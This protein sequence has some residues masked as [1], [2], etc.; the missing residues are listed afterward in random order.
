MRRNTN[1]MKF[2]GV[3]A[4][5]GVCA[6]SAWGQSQNSRKLDSPNG[7]TT[8]ERPSQQIQPLNIKPGLWETTITHNV[9]GAPPIPAEMLNRLTPEQRARMEERM[10]ANSAAHT[11]SSTS[12]GCTTKEDLQK[13]KLHLGKECT[14]TILASSSTMAKGKVSCESEGVKTTGSLEIE[15]LDQE[16][17]KGS[18]HAT[19]TTDGQV[20]NVDGTFTSKWV[21]PDCGTVK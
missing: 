7:A 20:M 4:V 15:V 19:V 8:M 18:S 1:I 16:H 2:V 12:R 10:R 5:A 17:L 14:P 9:T 11:T 6:L 21:G 3:V 13:D